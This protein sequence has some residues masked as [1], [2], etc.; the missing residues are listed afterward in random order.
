M[1]VKAKLE[2]VYPKLKESGG[3]DILR[4]GVQTGELVYIQPP[5]SGYSVPFLRDTA[6]LGQAIAFIRPIQKDLDTTPVAA[7]DCDEV[8]FRAIKFLTVLVF[9]QLICSSESRS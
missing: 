7:I 3:F 4:R 5:R 8:S 1:D 2:E 6:M 9:I